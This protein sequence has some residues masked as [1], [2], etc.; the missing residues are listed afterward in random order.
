MGLSQMVVS[1]VSACFRA[2]SVLIFFT[3]W[4]PGV[5][6]TGGIGLSSPV[7]TAP[8]WTDRVLFAAV[9]VTAWAVVRST[10][11]AGI[12]ML[13][14][15]SVASISCNIP[16]WYWWAIA[17]LLHAVAYK[18][19]KVAFLLNML[20]DIMVKKDFIFCIKNIMIQMYT[21][22]LLSNWKF[23]NYELFLT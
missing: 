23:L 1:N 5:T 20:Y 2:F 6:S 12:S 8:A 10:G 11:G 14:R 15:S 22:V 3:C 7:S 21:T 4:M 16:V 17:L 18:F 13:P 9:V 19:K